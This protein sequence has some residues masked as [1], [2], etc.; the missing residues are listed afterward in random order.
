MMNFPFQIKSIHVKMIISTGLVFSL[1]MAVGGYSI[2]RT[3]KAQR[4]TANERRLEVI[5]T[6]IERSLA[7]AMGKGR[8]EEVQATLEMIGEQKYI[9]TLRIF[10]DQGTILRSSRRDEIGKNVDPLYMEHYNKGH[11]RFV[12][13]PLNEHHSINT[14]IRPIPNEPRCYSCHNPEEKITG[15]L[16]IGISLAY[17]ER[18]IAYLYK[19]VFAA[20]F[21]TLG[22][23]AAMGILLQFRIVHRPLRELTNKIK[24]VE[25][26]NLGARVKLKSN[27]ELGRLGKSFNE[28]VQK[29]GQAQK[30]V[31]QYHQEQLARV[32]RLASVGEMAAGLAHEIR[33][34][35]AGISGAIQVITGDFDPQD[36]KREISSEILK[37]IERMNNIIKDILAYSR[38]S[39]PQLKIADLHETVDNALALSS[40]AAIKNKVK[41][42]RDYSPSLPEISF[43]PGQIQQVFLNIFLNAVQAM[44]EGGNLK[45]K[46]EFREDN[47]EKQIKVEVEDNGPGVS[48]EVLKK[49]FKPFFSTKHKGTGLGLSVVHTIIE[50]HSGSIFARSEEGKGTVF[51][52][53]LS[54][55]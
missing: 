10:S 54:V 41:I 26:G 3:Q 48:P 31:A 14:L 36:P 52:I 17:A 30:K 50:Q 1:C 18:D 15:I 43:D 27:D 7:Y 37:Q 13:K 44:P 16:E 38:P 32:D 22:I 4:L 53:T 19:S 20:V 9:K 5:E 39:S 28:M 35:L 34:P 12:Q 51:T 45:V 8:S 21:V 46:T 55:K 11:Y 29:L 33:N 40:P 25:T 24:Q 47:W 42:E 23:M 2:I 49:I 6:T